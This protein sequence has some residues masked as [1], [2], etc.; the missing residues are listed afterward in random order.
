MSR[1]KR[2][3]PEARGFGSSSVPDSR[4]KKSK[5]SPAPESAPEEAIAAPEPDAVDATEPEAEAPPE[6]ETDVSPE[7]LADEPLEESDPEAIAAESEPDVVAEPTQES[8]S[9]AD[10]VLELTPEAIAPEQLPEVAESRT[11]QPLEENVEVRDAATESDRDIPA[12]P[13]V[14][15]ATEATLT[16]DQQDTFTVSAEVEPEPETET[17]SETSDLSDT[18]AVEPKSETTEPEPETSDRDI[19]SNSEVES[20]EIYAEAVE[21]TEGSDT[22]DLPLTEEPVPSDLWEAPTQA[23]ESIVPPEEEPLTNSAIAAESDVVEAVNVEPNLA[24]ED[25][26]EPAIASADVEPDPTAAT[27]EPPSEPTAEPE[28]E[29]KISSRASEITPAQAMQSP[30]AIAL[31]AFAFVSALWQTYVTWVQG[32]LPSGA[33][34]SRK[35]A[36]RLG[37]SPSTIQR[38]KN[39][40]DFST[41]TQS[42]DPDGLAWVYEQGIFVPHQRP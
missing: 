34:S 13:E 21:A 33:L 26:T 39:Q 18:V 31:V 28:T 41:W 7:T 3:L 38:R 11:A 4:Q 30:A 24:P 42:L 35:L 40:A 16:E 22:P 2:K 9:E 36:R 6:P 23:I 12:T 8:T 19:V 27:P 20:Q 37:V 15:P 10:D 1:R 14:E 17:I 25:V 5:N 32:T 29:A